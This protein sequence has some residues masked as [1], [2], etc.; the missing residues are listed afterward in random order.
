[1]REL[2][3]EAATDG[4][5]V[6]YGAC[7]AVVRT[8][9]GP[10][11]SALEHL[12]RST[13]PAV[14]RA[15]LGPAGG[16]L[17]RLLPELPLRVGELPAPASGHGEIERHRLYTAV[18]DLLTSVSRRRPTVLLVEDAHWA[19]GPTLLLLRHLAR[20][21]T[22][23]AML[24]LV[25]FQ[26]GHEND[27][28]GL[29]AALADLRRIEGAT[30]LTLTGLTDDEVAEFVGR[31]AG[32]DT[33]A[34][35]GDLARTMSGLTDGNA[36]LMTELWRMLIETGTLEVE[37][38]R[39][40]L[41][42]PID[43]LGSPES[44][45]EVV[46]Q[47][48]ARFDAATAGVLEAAAVA[49]PEFRLDVVRRAAGLDERGLL[50]AL[51]EAVQT[52]IIEEVPSPVLAYRFTHELLRRALYD[53]LTAARRAELHLQVGTALEGAGAMS[54][55]RGLAEVAHHL[56]AAGS[57][58]DRGRAVEFNV[59]AARSAMTALAFDQAA[60][61]H[62]V[63][64]DLG[65]DNSAEEAK[66]LLDLGTACDS[67]GHGVEAIDAFAE[68]AD[69]ARARGDA[70]VLARAG[71]GLEE[72][73]WRSGIA[74]PGVLE[75]L[76]EAITGLGERE[77]TLRVRV[78]TALAREL[79]YHGDHQRAGIVYSN[80][81]EIARRLGDR[82]ALAAVLTQA[83]W[84]R[85]TNT[86]EEI[87][88][89]LAEARDLGDELGE[90]HVQHTARAYRVVT[91]MWLGELETARRELAGVAETV[92]RSGQPFVLSA[93][94]FLGSTIA[95]CEGH[96]DEAELRAERSRG[97]A[98]SVTGRD[99]SGI[100][101]IQMFSI[102]R[103]QGRLTELAPAIRVLAQSDGATGSWRPGLA[104]LLAEVGL[105]EEARHELAAIRRDGLE[106]YLEGA[107]LAALTYLTDACAATGDKEVAALVRAALAPYAGTTVVVG[108]GVA[109]YG[110]V[111][112]YLGMLAATLGDCDEADARFASALELN[113]RMGA[114]TWVAHTA[115]QHARML[116]ARGETDD[117]T[118]AT[119]MLAEAAAL[120]ERIGLATLLARIRALSPRDTRGDPL[121]D[122]LSPREVEIL[123][124][125][126]RGLSNRQIGAELHISEHTA[127][128][129]IRSILRK[130]SCANRTE[131]AT[132][133]HRHALVAT[134]AE[135]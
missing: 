8:P 77:S 124:L 103:E 95:L 46:T 118:R 42:R 23:G 112:R 74:H 97:C 117:A 85:R 105:E 81:M 27:A 22:D 1:V 111:D 106:R 28:D 110:A 48:L 61:C 128:N 129:H 24:L 122:G 125:V 70:D 75:L 115:F 2:V 130:T 80:A 35:V 107:W 91:W 21:A 113:R 67:A 99:T 31:A 55:G 15:D 3:H 69:I 64:L 36:F 78:L 83:Y 65:I 100:Y 40:R 11:L 44:V 26:D 16:E 116:L 123:R 79:T 98:P 53:R 59:R 30:R 87:L 33:K 119:P 120:A 82:R 56:A 90:L 6:L 5:L 60:A 96:L 32:G 126:V 134:P 68:A 109:C 34:D 66:V 58:G 38:G 18:A 132:Y 29:S 45:R 104:A 93:T 49:G 43:D 92:D 37:G 135:R 84:S 114:P 17:T 10:F 88:A 76:D 72:A 20:S 133:A 73:C 86:L 127:A 19:D 9:Y 25:T 51:D 63:A 57:L 62:R 13:E 71:I 50:T 7:D 89:L 14:L 12:V 108:H 94:E 4:I 121:P 41:T 47:R 101:G 102:R 52:R 131:A 39:A 54:R